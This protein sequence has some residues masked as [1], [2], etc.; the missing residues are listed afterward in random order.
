MNTL[1]PTR[2]RWILVVCITI[3]VAIFFVDRV[4]I[5]IAGHSIA[6]V[7]LLTDAQLGKVFSAFFLGYALFQIPAGWI[8]DRLGPRWVLGLGALWWAIFTTL[9]ASL[10]A[11]LAQAFFVI[12]IVRFSL[13]LGESII[14]PSS[15]R[16]VANWIPT[17][18]RGLANGLIFA[19]VGGGSAFA[20]PIVRYTL[21]HFGWRTAFWG[22]GALGLVA[23]GVWFWMGRD[24][25]DQHP[26]MNQAERK[27]IHDGLPEH[28]PVDLPKLSWGTM[29]GSKHV[30]AL[31]VSYFC[32]GYSPGIYFT[33]FFIYLTRVRGLNLQTASYYTMLPFAAMSI[34]SVI[35][36]WVADV[37]CRHFGRRWGRCGVAAIGMLGSG[38]F[39]ALSSHVS[40]AT[41]ASVILAAGA[42]SL[43]LSQSAFWALSA[44]FGKGSAGSLSGM[45]NMGSQLG[46]AVTAITTPLIAARF[47]WPA[48]FTTAA[49]LCVLGAAL[50]LVINPD[51][52]LTPAASKAKVAV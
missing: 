19:G 43:Y 39:L 37:V 50:W 9:T 48:S 35:G 33:W 5:S 49:A 32:F 34:G 13:G 12:W 45:M 15:N 36:G 52:S 3:M 14:F 7:Y 46:I 2:I 40:T 20:P 16:W 6:Q 44:D 4:N 29:L 11:G 17:A 18:E 47:G 51:L 41:T 30:W 28:G 1:V 26:W 23:A 24:N 10:P 21:E 31:T 27:W 42:G 22:C 38:I 8:V 25:P